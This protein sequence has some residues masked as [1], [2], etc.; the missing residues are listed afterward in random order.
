MQKGSFFPEAIQGIFLRRI[1]RF[2]AE[3]SLGGQVVRAH[4]PNPGRLWELLFPGRGIVL[5]ENAAAP[6]RVTP[7][8]VVAVHRDGVPI[9]LHT[10][11]TNRVARSLLEGHRIRGLESAEI[12]KPEATFGKSRFD[13]LLQNRGLPYLLEV[14]SCTLFGREM[15]MFPDAVTD[16]GRRHLLKLAS[17][18]E[19]GMQ[20]GVLF[21]VHWSRARFFLPDYHTDFAFARTFAD[22]RERLAYRAVSV[23]WNEDLSLGGEI[24]EL[25]I[26]WDLLEREARD[27]GSY[28]LILRI[29]RAVEVTVGSLGTFAFG[30][31]YYLYVGSAKKNLAK[32]LER[33][34]R[35]RKNFFWHIDYLR[36]HAE[37]CVALPIRSADDLEHDIARA[38]SR[39]AAPSIR[40]FGSSDCSCPTHLF[41]MAENPVHTP[42]FVDL[43]QHFRMDRLTGM[44]MGSAET[45]GKSLLPAFWPCR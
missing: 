27:R 45:P 7:Y 35:K 41:A 34:L 12:V 40:G 30:E 31:G 8:T 18:A 1:N 44:A 19:G 4:L 23:S 22:L 24:R 43:L 21:V 3:C 16:R 28:L 42:A 20:C 25:S 32:R 33:H 36:E 10:Q 37:T 5:V 9:L 15:A 14:K 6:Q 39:I 13:F 29:S 17:L 26:P 38:L 2:V 11:M